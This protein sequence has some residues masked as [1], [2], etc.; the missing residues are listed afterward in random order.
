MQKIS[1]DRS[2]LFKKKMP[3]FALLLAL[4]YIL[5]KVLTNYPAADLFS[6]LGLSIITIIGWLAYFRSV[7]EVYLAD[8]GLVVNDNKIL[9]TNIILLVHDLGTILVRYKEGDNYKSF[10][11][12]VGDSG[13]FF[14]SEIVKQLKKMIEESVVDSESVCRFRL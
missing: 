12:M 2:I 14:R 3:A 9:F 5:L 10:K 4:L 1:S 8:D 13:P 6:I 11:F 7:K